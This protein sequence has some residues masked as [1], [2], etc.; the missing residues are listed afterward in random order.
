MNADE[1]VC[2]LACQELIIRYFTILDTGPRASIGEIATDEGVMT[3]E[4][5]DLDL[6]AAFAGLPAEF[7]PIHLTHNI[8]VKQTGADTAEGECYVTAFNMMGK[9]DD[10]VPRPMPATPNRIGKTRFQFRKTG[11]GWRIQRFTAGER[12]VD[13]GKT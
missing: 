6:R 3:R 2:R 12:F 1:I 5:G 4:G 10:P 8:L 13:D 11:E 9:A 7:V